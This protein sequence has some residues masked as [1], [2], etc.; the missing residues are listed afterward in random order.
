MLYQV[1]RDKII[2]GWVIFQDYVN[3]T[4]LGNFTKTDSLPILGMVTQPG[5]GYSAWVQLPSLGMV[6]QAG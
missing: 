4:R 2:L 3:L 1:L 5:Y 6:T